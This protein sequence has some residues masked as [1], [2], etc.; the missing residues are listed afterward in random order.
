MRW[1]ATAVSLLKLRL[2]PKTLIGPFLGARLL[3]QSAG[4]ADGH[5]FFRGESYRSV[6][7]SSP[8]PDS[9]DG[10]FV[11]RQ[12][13][14]FQRPNAIKLQPHL[15]N[16]ASFIGTIIRPFIKFINH[17]RIFCVYSK[18]RLL[19]PPPGKGGR[20][21]WIFVDFYDKMARIASRHLKPG[22]FV[23]VSGHLDY[24][25]VGNN[26]GG[27]G[28]ALMFY[29]VIV[30]DWNFVQPKLESTS[31]SNVARFEAQEAEIANFILGDKNRENKEDDPQHLWMLF[32]ASPLE[33]WDNRLNKVFFL[34]Y[35]STYE[36]KKYTNSN[37]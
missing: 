12:A 24:F 7:A 4:E 36:I 8:T 20:P 10:S 28:K 3:S 37:P 19:P 9:E 18:L 35:A 30:K 31:Q 15:R 14:K 11:Y 26:D 1:A 22:D 32:F 27:N 21:L 13:L 25:T 29:K 33:W 23:Y 34:S 16:S 6:N 2:L 5:S 17:E